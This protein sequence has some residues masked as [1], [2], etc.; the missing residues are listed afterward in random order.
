MTPSSLK[1]NR[2]SHRPLFHVQPIG[3]PF[4][5]HKKIGLCRATESR[6]AW[7]RSVRHGIVIHFSS[8]VVGMIEPILASMSAGASAKARIKATMRSLYRILGARTATI[9]Q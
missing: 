9:G 7:L 8:S 6:R 2:R 5:I 4:M 3:W 1:R